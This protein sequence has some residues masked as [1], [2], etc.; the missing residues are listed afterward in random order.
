MES[1]KTEARHDLVMSNGVADAAF[2]PHHLRPSG[3]GA[4]TPPPCMWRVWAREPLLP[5]G[6]GLTAGAGMLKDVLMFG[7]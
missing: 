6:G 7:A 3:V 4:H 5:G 1:G 2:A